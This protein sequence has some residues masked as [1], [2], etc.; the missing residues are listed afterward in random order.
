MKKQLLRLIA[1]LVML[2]ILGSV[3]VFASDTQTGTSSEV[4][5]SDSFESYTAGEA[6]PAGGRYQTPAGTVIN[7]GDETHGKVLEGKTGSTMY[8]NVG[9]ADKTIEFSYQ[10]RSGSNFGGWGGLYVKAY[11]GGKDVEIYNI[12]SPTL[13]GGAMRISGPGFGVRRPAADLT[14]LG[15]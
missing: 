10:F 6:L 3:L 15:E 13:S 4:W 1:A 8:L 5:L 14:E 2:A 9:K 11:Y 12:F 7:S